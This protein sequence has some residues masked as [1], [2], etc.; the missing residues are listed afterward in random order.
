MPNVSNDLS[1][2]HNLKQLAA[3]N[4]GLDETL[5]PAQSLINECLIKGHSKSS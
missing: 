1:I 2:G 4:D 5:P 3:I